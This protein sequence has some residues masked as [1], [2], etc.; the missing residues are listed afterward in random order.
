MLRLICPLEGLK[1]GATS[2]VYL[3]ILESISL[4]GNY[5]FVGVFLTLTQVFIE[6]NNWM[7]AAAKSLQSCPTLCNPIECSPPGSPVPR[8]LQARTLKW[9][10]ISFSNAWKWKVKVKSLSRVRLPETPWTAAYQA[11][12]S[13]G[14][15]R[16]E[17][18]SGVPLPSPIECLHYTKY[19]GKKW[20]I[21]S[22][23]QMI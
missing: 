9:V 17:Y 8:I 4:C 12:P 20:K 7:S 16:Q 2:F 6:K 23:S 5:L 18:W 3:S 1:L 14:F 21:L 11:P 10:A 22:I 13:A 15:S 19:F